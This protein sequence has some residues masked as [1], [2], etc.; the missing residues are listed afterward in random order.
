MAGTVV[1]E[2]TAG[3]GEDGT[4]SYAVSFDMGGTIYEGSTASGN[5]TLENGVF[6][7]TDNEGTVTEG[8]V[9]TENTLVISLMASA[10]AKEPYEVSFVPA[11]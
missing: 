7:F 1:Y 9:T 11:P 4:F 6:T 10:M 2:Y 5:Y 8:V 3:I